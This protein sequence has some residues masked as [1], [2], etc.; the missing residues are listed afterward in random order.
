MRP[1][2]PPGKHTIR[3]RWGLFTGQHPSKIELEL[4][5]GRTYYLELVGVSR[6]AGNWM[7]VGSGLHRLQPESA[8]ARLQ[9]CKFQKPRT[10]AAP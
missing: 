1:Y 7:T 3:A 6:F 2:A 5:A 9:I 4:A 8:E 10:P